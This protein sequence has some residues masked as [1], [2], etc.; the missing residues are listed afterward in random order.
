MLDTASTMTA[1][2][3]TVTIL[4]SQMPTSDAVSLPHLCGD[5]ELPVSPSNIS[6]TDTL[7]ATYAS[8]SGELGGEDSTSDEEQVTPHQWAQESCFA[9]LLSWDGETGLRLPSGKILAPRKGNTTKATRRRARIKASSAGSTLGATDD[10]EG[11]TTPLVASL[12][13]KI[14]SPQSTEVSNREEGSGLPT[15]RNP[16][17]AAKHAET[18]K[19]L[20]RQLAN[21]RDSDRQAL[22]RLPAAQQRTFLARAQKQTEKAERAQKRFG[23]KMDVLGNK[24]VTE[25]F[26]NDV[27][28]GR[29]HRCRYLVK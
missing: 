23:A 26:V 10:S 13:L 7:W 16:P 6:Y 3:T 1:M 24:S 12:A 4:E 27:P 14:A 11:I 5:R 2:V 15:A 17:T 18:E 9:S 20:I 19:A 21:L 8:D 22:D 29:S 25:R 28:G